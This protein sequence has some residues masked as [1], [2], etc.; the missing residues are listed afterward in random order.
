MA[1]SAI[2]PRGRYF[3][4]ALALDFWPRRGRKHSN[5]SEP[6]NTHTCFVYPV[7][8]RANRFNRPRY[9]ECKPSFRFAS[10]PLPTICRSAGSQLPYT[11]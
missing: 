9:S 6:R 4:H 5:A 2:V 11:P 10:L 3:Q 8:A 7:V 1:V